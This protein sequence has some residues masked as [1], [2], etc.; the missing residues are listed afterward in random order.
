MM[1]RPYLGICMMVE[2]TQRWVV[3]GAFMSPASLEP[4]LGAVGL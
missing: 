1:T 2:W 4:V 3:S